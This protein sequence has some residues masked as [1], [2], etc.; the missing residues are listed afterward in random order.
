M[1]ES[2]RN[3]RILA[4]VLVL[5]MLLGGAGAILSVTDAKENARTYP[6]TEMKEVPSGNGDI[7]KWEGDAN[8]DVKQSGDS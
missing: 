3:K 7:T 2:L 8:G 4:I 6:G 5:L 1:N